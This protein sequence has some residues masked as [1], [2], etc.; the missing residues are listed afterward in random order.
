MSIRQKLMILIVFLLVFPMVSLLVISRFVLVKQIE[1]S[2]RNYLVNASKVAQSIMLSRAEKMEQTA[3]S[4]VRTNDFLIAVQKG[5]KNGISQEIKVLHEISDFPDYTIFFDR[6]G[7]VLYAEPDSVQPQ[8][9]ELQR[10]LDKAQEQR[11]PLISHQAIALDRIFAIGSKEYLQF[12]IQLQEDKGYFNYVHSLTVIIPVWDE[13]GNYQG[14]LLIGDI[15][16]NDP[17]LPERYSWYIKDSY[18][19]LSLY[20]VR[21]TSNIRSNYKTNFIGSVIPVKVDSLE[22]GE[23]DYYFGKVRI[24]DEMHF[25]L[26]CPIYGDENKVIGFLG[27]GIPEQKFNILQRVNNNLIVGQTFILLLVMLL[28]G[29]V[30]SDNITEP[31]LEAAR[32]AEEIA[33]GEREPV[34]KEKFL[35]NSYTE[36]MLLLSNLQR[37]ARELK[38]REEEK[39]EVL[40]QL[41]QEHQKQKELYQQL[42]KMNDELEIK[43]RLRTQE[44]EEAVKILQKSDQVKTRFLANM[45]HELR[46]PLN[47]IIASAQALAEKVL[48]ELNEKQVKYVQNIE[49]AARHLLHIINDILDIAKIQAGK[50]TLSLGIFSISELVASSVDEVRS[51]AE[52]KKLQ[53][54]SVHLTED[55]LVMVDKAKFKQI[56]YNLISNAIKFTPEGGDIEIKIWKEHNF[57]WIAVKDNGIGIPL[58]YQE[59]VFEEFEQLKN[60][61]EKEY[62]GTGL[63]LPL[64]KKLV[65][66]HGGEIF[67]FS[68]VGEGT[69]VVVK[70]PIVLTASANLAGDDLYGQNTFS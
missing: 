4:L 38:I 18:L 19:S 29:K 36:G 44:L 13:Q 23:K 64:T 20:D 42:Q 57:Y 63:G 48:G 11:K 39:R 62:A 60:S 51:W 7:K 53:I 70:M 54:K 67:L 37:M 5:D 9:Y 50:M 32:W 14:T 41:A 58:E 43:V 10:L 28:L 55:F 45:S 25:F 56:M 15:T 31:I 16:N 12:Q 17:F 49:T 26:D 6:Y 24:D 22:E 52:N 1:N 61:Y 34:I 66:L 30:M 21:I 69:E 59:K 27:V 2:A 47:I 33:R 68:R 3:T 8:I 35:H 46:T 65:E 40:E